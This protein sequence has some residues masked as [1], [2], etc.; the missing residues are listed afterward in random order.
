MAARTASVT[1]NWADTATWGGSSAPVAG[2]TVVINTGI[3]VTV[4]VSTTA[5]CGTSPTSAT[6]AVSTDGL[7]VQGTGQL[8]INGTLNMKGPLD[9]TGGGVVTI[10]GGGVLNVDPSG[11]A[12]TTEYRCRFGVTGTGKL[13]LNNNATI[14]SPVGYYW[15]QV[16]SGSVTNAGQ[17][18]INGAEGARALVQ[19]MQNSGSTQGWNVSHVI[20]SAG[21]IEGA[22]CDFD[23]CDEIEVSYSGAGTSDWSYCVWTNSVSGSRCITCASSSVTFTVSNCTFDANPGATGAWNTATGHVINECFFDGSFTYSGGGGFSDGGYNIKRSTAAGGSQNPNPF[24]PASGGTR[25]T[26]EILWKDTT[27]VNPHWGGINNG[28]SGARAVEGPIYLYEGTTEDGDCVMPD[29]TDN[30]LTAMRNMLFARNSSGGQ[31]GTWLSQLGESGGNHHTIAYEHCTG[32]ISGTGTRGISVGETTTCQPDRVVSVK[33]NLAVEPSAGAY[34]GTTSG[35][36]TYMQAAQSTNDPFTETGIDY[37]WVYATNVSSA[38]TAYASVASSPA[39]GTQTLPTAANDIYGE[40]PG[41]IDST[42]RMP[43]WAAWWGARIGASGDSTTTPGTAAT[44]V[45][46]RLLLLAMHD[47]TFSTSVTSTGIQLAVQW[48][49]RGWVPT[50]A[51]G[52][53]AGHDGKTPGMFGAWAPSVTTPTVAGSTASCTTNAADGTC[54]WVITQSA[55]APDWDRI[56]AGQDHTGA[57]V[58]AGFSGNQAVASTSINIDISGAALGGG[59]YYVHV[60]HSADAT[61]NGDAAQ[62]AYLRTSEPV[63]SSSFQRSSGLSVVNRI[64]TTQA[65]TRGWGGGRRAA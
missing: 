48:I 46:A 39:V 28:L 19:R 26:H 56:I 18:D 51:A 52:R 37:N 43:Q 64:L 50:N 65:V 22:Y 3:T 36:L 61:T 38:A 34:A 32:V 20:S 24:I 45:N 33:S 58:A 23:E 7:E 9:V 53:A 4:A 6:A 10:N 1:G 42:R 41:F 12:T 11:Q 40:D 27:N 16:G 49:R 30:V 25:V 35:L 13:V 21:K 54:Y 63:T 17:L 14:T 5:E 47:G 60:A 15:Y 29:P 59:N 31:V 8:V 57:T 55:T 2:D 44:A 62:E